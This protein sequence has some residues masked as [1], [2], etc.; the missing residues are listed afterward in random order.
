MKV[1]IIVPVYNCEKYIKKCIESIIVQ[2]Y[3]D[4]ELILIDDGSKDDSLRIC[5]QY[6]KKDS[7][8]IVLTQKNK[9][10]GLARNYGID[11]STGEYIM[12]CDSDD[13]LSNNA[14]KKFIEL[15]LEGKWDLII[16]GYNEFKYLSNGNIKLCGENIAMNKEIFS[17][18]EARNFYIE[19]H[20][21]YLN[22]AP[23]AKLYKSNIVKENKVYFG[24]FRRCQDTVFNIKYYEY[25]KTIKIV[26]DK[27][28]NYQTPNGNIYI[29][30][31]PSNMIDIRK[32]I[33]S[34]ITNTL[35]EWKVYDEKAR[36]YL[37]SVLAT[38][39]IVCCRLNY[40]N[41]WNFN[42]E[43]QKLYLDKLLSDEKVN[44]VLNDRRYGKK[45]NILCEILKSKNK[46]LIKFMNFIVIQLQKL[47]NKKL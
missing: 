5:K 41:N 12:F 33:D 46:T 18:E 9:G 3:K 13:F 15:A 27:L 42:K 36:I 39:I 8:I 38:D 29:S 25:V 45:K 10:S 43:Q 2:T 32:E 19:L 11:K 30:K 16:S 34:L 6:S 23:W 40:L 28:Y 1:S 37:N 21:K 7:R 14:I 44:E 31:F 35:K 4:W 47:K 24:D 26:N 20:E 17:Q 22:Q